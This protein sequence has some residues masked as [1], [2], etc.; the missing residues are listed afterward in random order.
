ME[1]ILAA[2]PIEFAAETRYNGI[3]LISSKLHNKPI[4]S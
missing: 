4:I 1:R 2:R 3:K